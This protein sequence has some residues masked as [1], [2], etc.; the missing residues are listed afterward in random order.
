M[1]LEEEKLQ[2][3]LQVLNEELEINRLTR[4]QF[5]NKT[6]LLRL[7]GQTIGTKIS[8][9]GKLAPFTLDQDEAVSI[10]LARDVQ[11]SLREELLPFM[12]V[13]LPPLR[14]PAPWRPDGS[15][16]PCRLWSA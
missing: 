8:V 16:T 15:S 5:N 2:A 12:I 3:E 11:I 10:A 13:T 4:Q 6:E 9:E 1:G 14:P 7:I